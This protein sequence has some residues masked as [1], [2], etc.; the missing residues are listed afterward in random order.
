MLRIAFLLA[1]YF[2]KRKVNAFHFERSNVYALLFEK[3]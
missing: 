2:S 3:R 1:F